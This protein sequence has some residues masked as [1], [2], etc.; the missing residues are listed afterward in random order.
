MDFSA[1]AV[2]FYMAIR[3]HLGE[4][5]SYFGKWPWMAEFWASTGAVWWD[6]LLAEAV[7]TFY[8]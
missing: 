5:F 4:V 7:V 2:K 8:V 6:M 3:P 1:I